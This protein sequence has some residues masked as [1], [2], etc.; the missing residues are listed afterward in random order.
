MR[1][2][3]TLLKDELLTWLWRKPE[4]MSKA[5]KVYGYVAR[6]GVRVPDLAT[7]LQRLMNGG[8]VD[9]TSVPKRPANDGE[10]ANRTLD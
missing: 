6:T 7:V 9:A 2:P 10:N 5:I 1:T 8:V 4:R 3:A